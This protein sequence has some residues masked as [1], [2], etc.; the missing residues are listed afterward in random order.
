MR[1][2]RH[3]I[4]ETGRDLVV[5][6]IHAT[7]SVVAAALQVAR[8]DWK[9]DRLFSVGDLVDRGPE[10]KRALAFL[11]NPRIHAIRGNH[12]DMFL[13]CYQ[14]S[15][16]DEDALRYWTRHN[17]MSW[18]MDL[19]HE[20]RMEFIEA[21]RKL[22]I[23]MEIETERGIVGLVHGEVPHGMDWNTFVRRIE[24][25]DHHVTKTALWGRSRIEHGDDSGVVGVDRL[26]C[27]HTIVNAPTRLGNVYYIDSGSFVG[28]RDNDAQNGRLTIADLC[29]RTGVFQ[30]PASGEFFD[31]R[32]E[33]AP[34]GQPF[35]RYAR[36]I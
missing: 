15:I 8:F 20:E 33:K 34:E 4:N 24:D 22:P 13:D 23:V 26:F 1:V 25:G 21:F 12:E 35:G 10:P 2:M 18:W 19:T 36:K 16:P 27:G 30:N 7:F 9:G 14:D 31:I 3:P 11:R 32:T 17:G 5:G 6:D 28:V 29:S